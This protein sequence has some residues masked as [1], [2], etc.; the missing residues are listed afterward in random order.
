MI[1]DEK[2]H[3]GAEVALEFMRERELASRWCVS[4]R[5][6]QRWR[7]ENDGPAW[8]TIGGSVRYRM[9]DILAFEVASRR[10]GSS[11]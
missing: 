1:H 2:S 9:A 11:A 5:T 4:Q 7:S 8:M 10:G 3:V 6:L